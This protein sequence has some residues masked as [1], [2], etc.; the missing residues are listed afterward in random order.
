MRATT[1]NRMDI[2]RTKTDFFMYK[3]VRYPA[4]TMFKMKNPKYSFYSDVTAVYKGNDLYP[5]KYCIAYNENIDISRSPRYRNGLMWK[6]T[7]SVEKDKL[8]DMIVEILPG[9]NFLNTEA[10]KKYVSDLDDWNLISKWIMYIIG[11]IISSI[12]KANVIGWIIL[13]IVFFVWRHNYREE[14]CIYYE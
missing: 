9:N 3:G 10:R 6:T 8:E 2:E 11:M 5:G 12:F 14:N 4:G 1:G 7:I 13:T